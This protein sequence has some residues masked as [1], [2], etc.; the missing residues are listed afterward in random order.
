[1][2]EIKDALTAELIAEIESRFQDSIILLANELEEPL[3]RRTGN[4]H[5]AIVLV[6]IFEHHLMM[7]AQLGVAEGSA[8]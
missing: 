6:R 1:M 5:R 8:L 3:A 4:I 7:N 2:S